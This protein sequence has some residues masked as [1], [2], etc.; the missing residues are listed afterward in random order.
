MLYAHW[1]WFSFSPRRNGQM[2]PAC[3]KSPSHSGVKG[4]LRDV[5]CPLSVFR[6]QGIT[7]S[8]LP[9]RGHPALS[10]WLGSSLLGVTLLSLGRETDPD[11]RGPLCPE[12]C[13]Q[14]RSTLTTLVLSLSRV[15]PPVQDVPRPGS[16]AL[17][18]FTAGLPP[19]QPHLL[20]LST[21]HTARSGP[22]RPTARLA[23]LLSPVRVGRPTSGPPGEPLAV[24]QGKV[25]VWRPGPRG[26]QGAPPSTETPCG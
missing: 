13:C 19:A 7:R 16:A 1:V 22:Q 12:V 21:H 6:G 5:F 24:V 2:F 8:S 26:S 3:Q 23:P 11:L 14:P 20:P 10:A 17:T 4:L 18:A 9:L 15:P 25:H